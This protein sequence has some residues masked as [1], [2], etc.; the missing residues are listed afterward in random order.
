MTAKYRLYGFTSPNNATPSFST[1]I[2]EKDNSLYVQVIDK[3]ENIKDF[4]R[5]SGPQIDCYQGSSDELYSS[6]D[7]ALFC[8]RDQFHDMTFDTKENLKKYL[9]S[10]IYY[11]IDSPYFYKS[12]SEFCDYSI[13]E[14]FGCRTNRDYLARQV[15]SNLIPEF[16][17]VSD[18]R[19]EHIRPNVNSKYEYNMIGFRNLQLEKPA[20]SLKSKYQDI[21]ALYEAF[22]SFAQ[23]KHSR[24]ANE[25]VF[26]DSLN[27]SKD[28][29][30]DWLDKDDI[31]YSFVKENLVFILNTKLEKN[32]EH[33][34]KKYKVKKTNEFKRFYTDEMIVKSIKNND[35]I[36]A[37]GVSL[38]IYVTSLLSKHAEYESDGLTTSTSSFSHFRKV[39][40]QSR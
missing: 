24:M 21:R 3:K 26:V 34:H 19:L 20:I 38:I 22:L 32:S 4:E 23:V 12:V 18:V 14:F 37:D 2:F 11:Y 17:K 8:V 33:R 31:D 39:T 5:I 16:T 40:K 15:I 10:K 27:M 9:Q 36:T 29:F 6:G 7:E 28:V 35:Q 13:P 25:K 1:P 30:S